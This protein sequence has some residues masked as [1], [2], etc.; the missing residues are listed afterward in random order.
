MEWLICEQRQQQEGRFLVDSDA[1]EKR[2]PHNHYHLLSSVAG[3][4]S[5]ARGYEHGIY[6]TAN[7]LEEEW[8]EI[9]LPTQGMLNGIDNFYLG[10]GGKQR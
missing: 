6:S 2:S 5:R 1:R 9:A 3:F 4:V 8:P 10:G 7:C